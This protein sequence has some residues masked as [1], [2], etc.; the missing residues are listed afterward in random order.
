MAPRETRT[1]P[2]FCVQSEHTMF[3]LH[4]LGKSQSDVAPEF[5]PPE[6]LKLAQYYTEYVF[7]HTRCF[8]F[9]CA[10][11]FNA[12]PFL[13]RSLTAEGITSDVLCKRKYMCKT[14][15]SPLHFHV[16]A[17]KSGGNYRAICAMFPHKRFSSLVQQTVQTTPKS[18][19][20]EC[21]LSSP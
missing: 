3:T 16:R 12:E 8:F 21:F 13:L 10:R 11:S 4:F 20:L 18:G 19:S 5:A 2:R 7:C 14:I 17:I 6:I 1:Q 15:S 9:F